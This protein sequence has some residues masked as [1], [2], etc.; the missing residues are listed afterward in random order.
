MSST[1]FQIAQLRQENANKVLE[2][3]S[4]F[5]ASFFIIA[6]LPQLLIRYVYA[7][8]P[9][10]E[11]PRTL[12]LIPVVVFAFAM[13][14]FIYA[15]VGNFIRYNRMRLLERDLVLMGDDCHC[16]DDHSHMDEMDD[17]EALVKEVEASMPESESFS[18][19]MKS[20]SKS[21]G[22]AKK[23]TKRKTTRKTSK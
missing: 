11:T 22:G 2:T 5:A 10:M 1:Q 21:K 7:N 20:S 17:L 3:I 19:A 18:E 6:M 8:Q 4:V 15:V 16:H 14:Y 9:I 12:E 23:T 13:A